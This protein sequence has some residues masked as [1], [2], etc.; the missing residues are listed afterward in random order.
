MD[1]E[2]AE[3]KAPKPEEGE[4]EAPEAEPAAAPPAPQ[5]LFGVAFGLADALAPSV[6]LYGRASDLPD[7]ALR[8]AVAG[9][10]VSPGSRE[11]RTGAGAQPKRGYFDRSV[12]VEEAA[13]VVPVRGTGGLSAD[14]RRV[15]LP[16]MVNPVSSAAYRRV[17]S[18]IA[19]AAEVRRRLRQA[20]LANA[21]AEAR[22]ASLDLAI[23][24]AVETRTDA[25]AKNRTAE[26][27]RLQ[28]D[29][30]DLQA[31]R[32]AAVEDATYRYRTTAIASATSALEAVEG[33]VSAALSTAA[34]PSS[35]QQAALAEIV[36]GTERVHRRFLHVDITASGGDVLTTTSFAGGGI[37][38]S[39]MAQST[40]VLTDSDG[41]VLAAGQSHGSQSDELASPR[42]A[43]A[44]GIWVIVIV[45]VA[46]IAFAVAIGVVQVVADIVP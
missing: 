21:S 28:R 23:A 26:A 15:V 39:G 44:S 11:T 46:T 33:F 32:E 34:G 42:S 18:L 45:L 20:T 19:S 9:E 6:A 13:S 24:K 38:V 12:K 41:N 29:I 1:A 25:V 3:A 36:M 37:K 16:S 35:L 30:A 7:D 2:K 43:I 27:T 4:G 10:L 22:L 8:S 40:F 14:V 17:L 31:Q 5:D